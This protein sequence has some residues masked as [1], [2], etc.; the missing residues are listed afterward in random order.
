[1]Y[2]KIIYFVSYSTVAIKKV[3]YYRTYVQYPTVISTDSG[4]QYGT[5][6]AAIFVFLKKKRKKDTPFVF[7]NLLLFCDNRYLSWISV[8]HP[9]GERIRRI[10]CTYLTSKK[11]ALQ[12]NLKCT[13]PYY[14]KRYYKPTGTVRY[15]TIMNILV[16]C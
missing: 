7:D 8:F 2:E 3:L 4:Q 11:L 14:Y 9:F 10:V 13:V 5:S 16:T 6:T 15:R 1:M 12:I